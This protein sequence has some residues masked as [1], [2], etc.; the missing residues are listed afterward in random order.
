MYIH[1]LPE[2]NYMYIKHVNYKI[3]VLIQSTYVRGF[4][5]HQNIS[6]A[7]LL[8]IYIAFQTF[9]NTSVH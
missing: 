8:L 2:S 3:N 6:F 1:V 9:P 5:K 4:Q 7:I